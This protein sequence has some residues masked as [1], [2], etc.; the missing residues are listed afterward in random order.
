MSRIVALDG[1]SVGT[2]RS[3]GRL[4]VLYE[5]TPERRAALK[6]IGGAGVTGLTIGG[7]ATLGD[8]VLT[9]ATGG[10]GALATAM[11]HRRRWVRRALDR[12]ARLGG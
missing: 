8:P 11:L 1:V 12:V 2:G 7:I 9:L 3:T 5:L 10:V 4:A 6:L